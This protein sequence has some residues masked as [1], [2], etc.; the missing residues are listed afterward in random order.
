LAF[1]A[2]ASVIAERRKAGGASLKA[3]TWRPRPSI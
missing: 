3:N 1:I 2:P